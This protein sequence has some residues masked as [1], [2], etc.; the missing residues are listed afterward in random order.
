MDLKKIA[1]ITG[2]SSGIGQ[3]IAVDLSSQ[4]YECFLLSRNTDK[5]K[6]TQELCPNSKILSLD[7]ESPEDIIF[8]SEN[9]LSLLSNI[10]NQHAVLINNAGIVERLPFEKTP[11]TSWKKQFQVNLFGPV[12]LTQKLL[13]FLEQQKSARI[14][15]IS[16]TLGLKP[17]QDTSA[18]SASKSAMN[19][20]TQSLALE[21]ASKNILASAICPGIIETPIQGFYKTSDS[22]LRNTLNKMQ[23]LNR[24]GQPEDISQAVSFLANPLNTWMTGVILPVDGGISLG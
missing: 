5:L 14:I 3:Q 4:G 22:N 12:L 11:M 17:I 10:S 15:N 19:N 6:K 1:I 13:P 23:P 7:L 16:S 8:K 9:L 20:W 24:V 21:L 18:Y 2:A